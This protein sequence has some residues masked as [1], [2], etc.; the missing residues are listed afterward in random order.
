MTK[1]GKSLARVKDGDVRPWVERSDIEL[2]LQLPLLAPLGAFVPEATLA[3]VARRFSALGSG[4]R[5]RKT[6]ARVAPWLDRVDPSLDA[7]DLARGIEAARVEN[8]LHAF[9]ALRPGGWSP[10]IE[11]EGA[12][13]LERALHGG[14][15][16]VL[17][18]AHF[19]FNGYAPKAA[20]ARLGRPAAHVSRPEH[21]FSKSRYGVAVLNPMRA[22][23]EDRHLHARLLI[24]RGREERV[25]RDALARL[26]E[27]G[28][29]TVTAGAWEGRRIEHGALFGGR[30]PVAP[31]AAR[32]ARLAKAPLLPLVALREFEPSGAPVFRILIEAPLDARNG[33]EAA[34]ALS[35]RLAPRIRRAPE[36]WR[37]WSYLQAD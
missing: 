19:V 4:A 9:R 18:V 29:V 5:V 24:E 31:G 2:T 1:H 8:R 14:R 30:Y 16:A 27:N 10:R 7:D 6:T 12:D 32:I 28:V 26:K 15:G 21:G 11:I 13:A 37:G 35:D 23:G 25:V 17:W 22:R 20:L 34:E 3:K 36:Q 33:A